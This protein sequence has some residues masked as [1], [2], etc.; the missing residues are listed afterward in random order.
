MESK[1]FTPT[2]RDYVIVQNPG[3]DNEEIIRESWGSRIAY[4][5]VKELRME[6]PDH[7]FDVMKRLPDGTLTTEF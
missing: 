5:I 3:M 2:S 6:F 1:E 7:E 4:E